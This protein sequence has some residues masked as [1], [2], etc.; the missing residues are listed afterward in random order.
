[1]ILGRPTNLWLGAITAIAGVVTTTLIQL[2]LD[3]VAVGTIS[4]AVVAALG[5]I[6]LL[7]ANQPPIVNSGDNIVVQTPSGTPNVPATVTLESSGSVSA[8]PVAPG[9]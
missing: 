1:M 6:V 2:G 9:Q 4:G 3:P 8:T 5:A 7:V